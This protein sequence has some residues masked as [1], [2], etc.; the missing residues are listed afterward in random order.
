M[1]MSVRSREETTGSSHDFKSTHETILTPFLSPLALS[2]ILL[3]SP[4]Y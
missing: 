4:L 2:L 3:S 1:Y